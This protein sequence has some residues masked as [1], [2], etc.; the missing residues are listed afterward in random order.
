MTVAGCVLLSSCST[1]KSPKGFEYSTG[2]DKVFV[3]SGI[4]YYLGEISG[5][6]N[7]KAFKAYQENSIS[8]I[9]IS[10]PGGLVSDGISLARWIDEKELP[11][12]VGRVCAS[13]CANYVLVAAKEVYLK[14]DSMLIWHGSSYQKNINDLVKKGKG[15]AV[16]WRR[17][18]D[19]FFNDYNVSKLVTVCGFHDVGVLDN[20]LSYFGISE[21]AGF[22]Y[23]IDALKKFGFDNLNVDSGNWEPI[24]RFLGKRVIVSNYCANPKDRINEVRR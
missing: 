9:Y 20:I 1:L 24:N 12:K 23:S 14:P 21:I 11:L 6:N 7:N 10:S 19:D 3:D 8:S 17:I 16:K 2:E 22:T 5:T 4:L 15:F 13:S 18:E